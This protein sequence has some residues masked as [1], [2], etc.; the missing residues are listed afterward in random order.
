MPDIEH[1]PVPDS[2]QAPPSLEPWLVL[3]LLAFLPGFLIF[4]LPHDTMVRAL[5]PIIVSVA[6]LFSASLVM[7]FRSSRSPQPIA[8]VH[9][10]VDDS[11]TR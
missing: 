8:E 3:A 2:G 1:P 10:V 11:G 9:H 6:A 4:A 5:V 7:L